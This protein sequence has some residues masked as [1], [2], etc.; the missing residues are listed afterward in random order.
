MF[1]V[2]EEYLRSETKFSGAF[3]SH[4][5]FLINTEKCTSGAFCLL[6]ANYPELFNKRPRCKGKMLEKMPSSKAKHSIRLQLKHALP[7]PD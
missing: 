4:Y 2:I 7:F 1:K 5:I 3:K 6:S